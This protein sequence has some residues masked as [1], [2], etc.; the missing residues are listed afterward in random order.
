MP[1]VLLRGGRDMEGTH[2]ERRQ[3]ACKGGVACCSCKSR[4]T[5][6]QH[7][8]QEGGREGLYLAPPREGW[9]Q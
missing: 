7:Q 8:E 1:A 2:A 5:E 4:G 3:C 6:V 9:P